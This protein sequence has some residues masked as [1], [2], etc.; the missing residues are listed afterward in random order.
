MS[1]VLSIAGYAETSPFFQR[2]A[3]ALSVAMYCAAQVPAGVSD[4]E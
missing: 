4:R 2:A 3:L 1:L